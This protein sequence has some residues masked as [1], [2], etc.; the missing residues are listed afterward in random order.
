[1]ANE[2][3][4][5]GFFLGMVLG[6]VLGFLV[7]AYLTSEAGRTGVAQLRERTSELTGDPDELRAKA[8]TALEAARGAAREAIQEGVAAARE[9]RQEL[10]A[11][12]PGREAP[13]AANPEQSAGD[14]RDDG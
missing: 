5:G 1:M 3:G 7:G 9:R 12:Q 13:K 10:V 8:T 14:A 11:G 6:G 2:R 4:G